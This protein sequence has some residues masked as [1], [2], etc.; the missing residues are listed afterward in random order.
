MML[1]DHPSNHQW[2]TRNGRIVIERSFYRDGFEIMRR[3]NR[4][5]YSW[6][7]DEANDVRL[8]KT[9]VQAKAFARTDLIAKAT[10]GPA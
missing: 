4:R 2:C 6:V 10:G 9:L 8:F 7:R 5:G 3:V 1:W